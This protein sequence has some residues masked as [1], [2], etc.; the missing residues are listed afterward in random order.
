M[1]HHTQQVL[2]IHGGTP[3]DT[4]DDYIRYLS[5]RVPELSRIRTRRDWKDRLQESLGD[6]FDV[7]QPRM[8][9]NMNAQY[10]E[11]ELWFSKILDIADNNIILVGHSLGGIF[12]LKYLT[13]HPVQKHIKALHIVASPFDGTDMDESL[14]SFTLTHPI[15]TVQTQVANIYLYYSSD[16]PAVPFAHAQLYTNALP[17]AVLRTFTDKGHFNQEA[18]PEIVED[19]RRVSE[20]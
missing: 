7:L 10:M 3:F 18:F 16:D 6:S 2:V 19:I 9:N 4:Y 5:A 11:W 14:A 1:S 15:D 12:L 20:A 13:E 17:Y 8:P